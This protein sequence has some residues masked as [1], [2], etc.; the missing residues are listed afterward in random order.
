MSHLATQ[1]GYSTGEFQALQ[2]LVSWIN[3]LP[4]TCWS[5]FFGNRLLNDSWAVG[6]T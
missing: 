2:R 3:H 4:P 5:I 6:L 1:H